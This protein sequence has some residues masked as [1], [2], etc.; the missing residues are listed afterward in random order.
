MISNETGI[1]IIVTGMAVLTLGALLLFDKALVIAGH[2]LFL[3]GFVV[4][5][6][7][8]TFALFQIDKLQGTCFFILGVAILFFKYQ[9]LGFLLEMIGLFLIFKTLLPNPR[10]IFFNIFFRP[11]NSRK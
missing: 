11:Q 7:S 1:V 8:K 3:A 2:F 9:L 5:F 4:L 6:R 10:T